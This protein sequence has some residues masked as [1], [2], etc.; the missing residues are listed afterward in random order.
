MDLDSSNKAVVRVG[1]QSIERYSDA[2]VKRSLDEIRAR[3]PSLLLPAVKKN[4]VLL[5]ASKTEPI[6]LIFEEVL[7]KDNFLV[8]VLECYNQR[9]LDE[10]VLRLSK[11]QYD[12][13]VPTNLGLSPWY[14]PLLV[15][16]IRTA[17]GTA[18]IVAISGYASLEVALDLAKRGIDDFIPLPF[19]SM[20]VSQRINEILSL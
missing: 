19:E 5:I 12:L 6:E 18:K 17:H 10:I 3:S 1:Q 20:E 14:I 8:D 4:K 9:D 15:S 13:V 7:Y 16:E 2:L 11:T